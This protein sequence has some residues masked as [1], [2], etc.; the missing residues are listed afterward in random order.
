MMKKAA[1]LALSVIA[2]GAQAATITQS[3]A[4]VLAT[5]EINQLFSVNLFDASMGTLN[6]VSI[7]LTGRAVSSGSL[8]STAAQEQDF[9]F[10]SNIRLRLQGTGIGNSDV[11]LSLFSFDNTIA[12]NGTVTL[13]PVDVNNTAS[14]AGALASFIGAGTANFT[15]KS[16]VQNTQAGGGGNIN[17]TQATQAGCGIDVVYDYTVA[18]PPA[19]PEP[20]SMA[21]VGL[22]LAGLGLTARR[23][24]AK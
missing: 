2:M 1:V 7:S 24:A 13:G 5:T 11:N 23:R 9:L 17:A 4:L 19:V 16:L 21:L 18:P 15:C 3:S 14:F 8:V 10:A 20:G 12:R 6:S 22:A